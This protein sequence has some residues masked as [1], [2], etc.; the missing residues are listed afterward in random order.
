MQCLESSLKAKKITYIKIVV[1]SK[2]ELKE[3]TNLVNRIF[4]SVSENKIDGF[5]IP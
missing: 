5:I 2:T 1:S 4:N 3:F